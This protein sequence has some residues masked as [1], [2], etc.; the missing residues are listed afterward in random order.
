MLHR[1]A[2]L[3]RSRS[4]QISSSL[5]PPS[6]ALSFLRFHPKLCSPLLKTQLLHTTRFCPT[7][8]TVEAT[9]RFPRSTVHN[10][11][12]QHQLPKFLQ[13]FPPTTSFNVFISSYPAREN[14]GTQQ[15]LRFADA[16]LVKTA[17]LPSLAHTS[18]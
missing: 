8:P 12:A 6:T 13:G 9:H 10:I 1:P 3:F 2:N 5:V 18:S 14:F 15:S 16:Q 17:E 4:Q 7:P 11:L